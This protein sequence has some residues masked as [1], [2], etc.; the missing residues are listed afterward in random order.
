MKNI[1]I[2]LLGLSVI[3]AC[4]SGNGTDKKTELA[5][6]KKEAGS[7][8]EKISKLESELASTNPNADAVDISVTE[9][10]P[11]PFEHYIEVQAKVD[12][13]ENVIVNPE[14]MGT[15]IKV[16][17]KAGDK[18]SKGTILAELDAAASAKGLEE[19][20]NQL[21]FAKTIY[22]KQKSLWDQKVGSEVQFLTAQNNYQAAEKR[23]AT[24]RESY[25]MSRLKSPINGTVDAVDIKVGQSVGPQTNAIRVVNLSNLKVKAEVAEAYVSKVNPGDKVVVVFPDINKELTTKLTYSGKVIDPLNRTFRVEVA[26]SPDLKELHP[27]MVAV[28]KIADYIAP[29]TFSVP[30]N[31]IQSGTEG[32]YL[33]VAEKAGNT[34]V[35]KKRVV[36]TGMTYNGTV[37]ITEGLQPGDKVITT[38]YQELLEGEKI[39]F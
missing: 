27:N 23:Y 1:L 2:L 5:N 3:Y 22:E 19:A 21:D 4:S 6:L 16:N 8:Q 24:M 28:L 33:F 36:K 20:Q 31:V 39:K 30:V 10:T 11:K 13:D 32:N 35:A 34:Q 7:I 25:D 12:G 18:V 38:G 26:L 14:I 29:Q 17:V 37:E 15:V 9:M